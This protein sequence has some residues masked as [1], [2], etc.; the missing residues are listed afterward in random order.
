MG[1]RT[2]MT[3]VFGG[4]AALGLLTAAIAVAVATQTHGEVR[5]VFRTVAIIAVVLAILTGYLAAAAW[6]QW[7]PLRREAPS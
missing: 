4:F 5:T 6:R 7:W 3:A 1:D 2:L